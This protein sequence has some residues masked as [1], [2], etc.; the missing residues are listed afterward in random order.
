[1]IAHKLPVDSFA[2]SV[3]FKL[4]GTATP[5]V[6][7]LVNG[8][9]ANIGLLTFAPFADTA[10]LVLTALA[11]SVTDDNESVKIN[12][13][14][15]CEDTATQPPRGDSAV[16]FIRE[17]FAINAGPDTFRCGTPPVQLQP[18]GLFPGDQLLWSPTG[19]LSCTTCPN[20]LASPAIPTTYTLTVTDSITRCVGQG[21]V[22]VFADEPITI[23][24]TS[25][26]KDRMVKLLAGT[27]GGTFQYQ[28][29]AHATLR[30][31]LNQS[32]VELIPDDSSRFYFVT[33]AYPSGCVRLDSVFVEVLPSPRYRP[34][35]TVLCS[36][37]P[38]RIDLF[39]LTPDSATWSALQSMVELQP[40]PW[41]AIIPASPA[42]Y[43]L[44]GTLQRGPCESSVLALI[45]MLK[46][47]S[48][49]LLFRIQRPDSDVLEAITFEELTNML[50][51]FFLY[52]EPVDISQNIRYQ[53]TLLS[54]TTGVPLVLQEGNVFGPY[55]LTSGGSYGLSA[56]AR[57]VSQP[58]L[59]EDS[60]FKMFSL[61]NPVI[62][63]VVTPND[64]GLNDWFHLKHL[65]PLHPI[66]VV[67]IDRWGRIVM[68]QNDY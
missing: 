38:V 14:N 35:D 30:P 43:T 31:P 57:Y 33:I 3:P 58:T 48:V 47:P 27:G 17:K 28:W 46:V 66:H 1:L 68:K 23:S 67:I 50:P 2:V 59:C 36:D 65:S 51:P 11:D 19:S 15:T 56:V 52:A 25:I 18:V 7:Y 49:D 9:S 24:D 6:D 16:V 21:Q 12:L 37:K 5:G 26:C 60:I 53:W 63:N 40:N 41:R 45:N 10:S 32:A 44:R 29:K 61:A 34:L 55:L 39:P 62:P 4:T 20:P 22:T 8:Q 42:V 13:Y 54:I 64:D